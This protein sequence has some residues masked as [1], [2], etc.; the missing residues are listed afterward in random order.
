MDATRAE[1]L[2]HRPPT[3]AA[4]AES[5]CIYIWFNVYS[6]FIYIGRTCDFQRRLHEHQR[7]TH[8][9]RTAHG[10]KWHN[11]SYKYKVMAKVQTQHWCMWPILECDAA[12]VKHIESRMI[13]R[14]QPRLNTHC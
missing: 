12:S 14:I 6:K 5:H 1:E 8:L 11:T 7:A 4:N 2:M 3:T 9:A 10:R 13:R